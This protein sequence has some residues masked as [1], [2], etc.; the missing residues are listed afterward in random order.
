MSTVN[1]KRNMLEAPFLKQMIQAT[2]NMWRLGWDERNGGN[3]SVILDEEEVALY[4]E[5]GNAIRKISLDFP[6]PEL[7]GKYFLVTASGSYFKNI[8]DNPEELLGIIQVM[9]G[10]NE[11]DII[12]GFA[13]GGKPTSELPSHFMSHI[14]RLKHDDTHRVIMHNHATNVVAMTFTHEL[15][16]AAFTKSL[17]Q[18]ESECIIVFPDG[19]GLLPWMI[20]GTTEIGKE[21]AKKMN[22]YRLVVWPHHGIF[23]TGSSIDDAFG[24]IET[25]EKA[26]QIYMLIHSQR[27]GVKQVITDDQLSVLAEAFGV[28]PKPGIL[29]LTK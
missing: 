23:G 12:W 26:A 8:I 27:G 5:K 6:V 11:L 22:E 20:P 25:A 3:V 28:T 24:L 2:Q 9:D 29:Q 21:T 17:W 18:M 15:D 7:A 14:V 19:V 13:N 16:E 1:A 10:G 4:I